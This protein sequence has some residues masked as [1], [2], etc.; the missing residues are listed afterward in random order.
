MNL[1]SSDLD[2]NLGYLS[3]SSHGPWNMSQRS[4]SMGT[5]RPECRNNILAL[6]SERSRECDFFGISHYFAARG[7]HNMTQTS[8]TSDGGVNY[9]KSIPILQDQ[10]ACYNPKRPDGE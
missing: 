4:G 3:L 7:M 1:A 5:T 9:D 6:G 2:M 8:I 10:G